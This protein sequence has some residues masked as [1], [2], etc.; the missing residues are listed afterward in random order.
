MYCD[1]LEDLPDIARDGRKAAVVVDEDVIRDKLRCAMRDTAAG[2]PGDSRAVCG[3]HGTG[4]RV[5]FVLSRNLESRSKRRVT[6]AKEHRAEDLTD[7]L[8]DR[9][10]QR[11]ACA[12]LVLSGVAKE[13][14]AKVR[15]CILHKI[16]IRCSGSVQCSARPPRSR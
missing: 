3:R 9:A 14:H 1:L 5:S 11:P 4:H 12:D 10:L 15:R 6:V 16:A 13:T 8:F 7:E 2:C